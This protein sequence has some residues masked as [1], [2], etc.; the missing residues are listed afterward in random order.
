[1]KAI[2]DVHYKTGIA[3]TALVQFTDFLDEKPLDIVVTRMKIPSNY[4]PGEF[5]KRELPCLI[6]AI[7]ESG[8]QY[9]TIII[10]GYVHM[11]ASRKGLGQHLFEALGQQIPITGIAKNPMKLATDFLPVRRGDSD[12]PLFVSTIS[13][14]LSEMAE[15]VKKMHGPFRIPT[16]V[17]LADQ[18]ARGHL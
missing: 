10:D 8:G 16:L 1:M 4:V 15:L 9:D 11:Q 3:I 6:H 2:L 17:K 12:K 18:A 13:L 14:D 7:K 5:F